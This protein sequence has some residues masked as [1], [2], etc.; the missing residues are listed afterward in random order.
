M[1]TRSPA[2]VFWITG[3]PDWPVKLASLLA[4]G[5]RGGGRTTG[6]AARAFECRDGVCQHV[7]LVLRQVVPGR[8]E[9]LV[10]LAA[11]LHSVEQLVAGIA[12]HAEQGTL[13]ADGRVLELE[14][15]EV[16]GERPVHTNKG[17]IA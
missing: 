14:G 10:H 15:A 17:N 9:E 12:D 4:R 2:S 1:T 3:A 5:E 6:R 16:S 8:L 13:L 11:L 7:K